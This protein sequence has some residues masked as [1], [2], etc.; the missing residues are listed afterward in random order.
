MGATN[1]KRQEDELKKCGRC[2]TKYN[3]NYVDCP[4]CFRLKCQECGFL[5]YWMFEYPADANEPTKNG[6]CGRCG[7]VYN[8]V[9][10]V[11]RLDETGRL[12]ACKPYSPMDELQ[13]EW[14]ERHRL[15]YES[16]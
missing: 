4:R 1:R 12:V 11:N 10:A 13:A 6:N 14:A 15:R 8:Y 2:H 9:V 16:E 3:S 7:S 5:H